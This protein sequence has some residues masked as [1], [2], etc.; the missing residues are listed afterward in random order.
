M[1]AIMADC[2]HIVRS[3]DHTFT[4]ADAIPPLIAE[5]RAGVLGVRDGNDCHEAIRRKGWP[6]C[7]AIVWYT[8]AA[9]YGVDAAAFHARRK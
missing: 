5:H 1:R 8:S 9:G 2:V 4:H 6:A 3:I 7:R